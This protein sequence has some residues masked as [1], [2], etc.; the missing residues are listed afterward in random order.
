MATTIANADAILKDWYWGDNVQPQHITD[1]PLLNKIKTSKDHIVN[2]VGGRQVIFGIRFAYGQGRGSRSAGDPL[3]QAR[4]QNLSQSKFPMKKM[5][6]HVEIQGEA[7]RASE[8]AGVKSFINLIR[9]ETN[10]A[11]EGHAKELNQIMYGDGTGLL[12]SVTTGVASGLG[13]ASI[14]VDRHSSLRRWHV[15]GH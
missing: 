9:E 5:I 3:P 13:P 4:F 7:W 8:G 15:G 12:S 11:L 6:S 2:N 10:D 14:V 1:T